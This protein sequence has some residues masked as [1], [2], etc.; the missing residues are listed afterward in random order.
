MYVPKRQGFCPAS[1]VLTSGRGNQN[2]W[3]HPAEGKRPWTLSA[4]TIS[5]C[6]CSVEAARQSDSKEFHPLRCLV[7]E[8]RCSCCCC[9]YRVAE[10]DRSLAELSTQVI[11]RRHLVLQ[12]LAIEIHQRH[13]KVT[14]VTRTTVQLCPHTVTLFHASLEL[15][16]LIL[17]LRRSLRAAHVARV[18]TG[19]RAEENDSVI[20][21]G[22][23]LCF[24]FWSCGYSRV[25][26]HHT[27]I[28]IIK[29]GD[30]FSTQQ[31]TKRWRR[32]ESSLARRRT[33]GLGSICH[34]L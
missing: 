18:Y 27:V 32:F 17:L 28:I 11:W 33:G 25:T 19:R 22:E 5:C 30:D 13:Q 14:W 12:V 15:Y 34:A 16:F 31:Q 24:S 23:F 7:E 1:A 26:S 3:R 6:T 21:I 4:L 20:L 8:A 10:Y 29:D 9:R 2:R